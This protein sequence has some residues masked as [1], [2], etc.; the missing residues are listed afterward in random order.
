MRMTNRTP[1]LLIVVLALIAL[2]APTAAVA[3][4]AG[5]EQYVDPFQN[6][7]GQA[8]GDQGNSGAGG[9][10]DGSGGGD[11]SAP[12][13]ATTPA[14]AEVPEGSA[15]GAVTQNPATG[16]TLPRTGLGVVAQVVA[17]GFL[18]LSGVTLRRRW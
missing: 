5:D 10:Q 12:A 15:E 1:V 17:G 11:T 18:L 16:P 7:Q 14:P 8:G 6:E 2:S 9:G 4:S 3:Q 13:P